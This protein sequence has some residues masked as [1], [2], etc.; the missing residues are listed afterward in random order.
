[1][2]SIT[3]MNNRNTI[4]GL[5]NM[6]KRVKKFRYIFQEN[7][8]RRLKLRFEKGEFDTGIDMFLK[9][10]AVLINL[11]TGFDGG[12]ISEETKNIIMGLG[13][14]DA[15]IKFSKL[16]VEDEY[17]PVNVDDKTKK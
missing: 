5:N 15:V 9:G 1:M 16:L 8:Y 6:D 2:L 11:Q 10:K 12:R 13:F 3:G 17:K 14:E 4:V 7:L